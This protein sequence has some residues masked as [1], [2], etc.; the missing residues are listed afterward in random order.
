MESSSNQ[1]KQITN[2]IKLLLIEK[3]EMLPYFLVKYEVIIYAN[4][5][6][7]NHSLKIVYNRKVCSK[8]LGHGLIPTMLY[9][10]VIYKFVIFNKR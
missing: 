7:Y 2:H 1:Y 9:T 3:T 10:K 4:H 8:Y 6:R 5:Y